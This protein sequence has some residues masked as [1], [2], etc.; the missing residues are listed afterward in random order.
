M[1]N[2]SDRRNCFY[3]QTDR[4]LS[5]EDYARYFLN[6][7]AVSNDVL[8]TILRHGIT[9]LRDTAKIEIITPDENVLKGNVNIVRKI[10]I[11]DKPFIA[12]FHPQGII[13]G[14]FHAEKLALQKAKEHGVP[15]PEVVDIHQ[16]TQP[17]DMDFMLMTVSEGQTL[18]IALQNKAANEAVIL[19]ECGRVMGQI[20]EISVDGYGSFDN[21]KAKHEKLVG[22]H[23][24]YHDFIHAGLDENLSRLTHFNILSQDEKQDISS[25]F[26]EMDFEPQG[27]PCLIHNDFADW[28]LLTDNLRVT[29]V[30]DWDECHAGDPIADL[31]CWSTFFP[32]QRYASFLEGYKSQKALPLDYEERFHFYRLRY[33]VS[34][35]ALRA[36]RR[37]VDDCASLNELIRNGTLALAEERAWFKSLNKPKAINPQSSQCR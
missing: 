15:V 37:L 21:D 2:L 27:K 28:N 10:H 31:A 25:I 5:P 13:N 8:V 33:S 14:Y 19:K 22:L 30:L 23:N 18:S 35:M 20:H 16:A 26:S 36:K 1:L 7:Q 12:R 4:N 32:K 3:W 17:T 9:G 11:D 34:K 6:R 24:S 29:A